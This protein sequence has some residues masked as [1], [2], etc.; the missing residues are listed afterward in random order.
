MNEIINKLKEHEKNQLDIWFALEEKETKKFL[1]D[2]V[3]FADKNPDEIKQ[4]CYSIT[5]S[6]FSSLTIVYEALSEYSND[7]TDF[8]ADEFIRIV[9]VIEKGKDKP[10]FLEVLESI[11]VESIYK[12]NDAAFIKSLDFLT[13]KLDTDK[14]DK[15]NIHLLELID[16]FILEIDDETEFMEYS[17]WISKVKRLEN[18]G[19]KKVKAKAKEV[20]SDDDS[21]SSSI[22]KKV[23]N[24]FRS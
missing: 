12:K 1:N 3:S 8:L 16:N 21:N 22:F 11:D 24:L 7:W 19:S 20:L 9:N 10:G 23:F 18:N 14:S 5:L 17:N 13:S 2:V 15:F 6:E 4:Y